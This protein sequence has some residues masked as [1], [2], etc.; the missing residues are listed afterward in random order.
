MTP[1]HK[2][3]T[4][5]L[6]DGKYFIDSY[7][8]E[9]PNS[10]THNKYII[11]DAIDKWL[12]SKQTHEVSRESVDAIKRTLIISDNILVESG[13]CIRIDHLHKRLECLVLP[14]PTDIE[15]E[16]I[17]KP[18]IRL[19]PVEQESNYFIMEAILKDVLF[20]RKSIPQAIEDL[21]K[22][23]TKQKEGAGNG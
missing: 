12:A 5:H 10:D 11:D 9:E 6:K 17:L 13:Q 4:L 3:I 19:K 2:P 18:M 20:C 8:M 22:Q 15:D 14:V 1:L 21:N 16:S 23:F 7:G